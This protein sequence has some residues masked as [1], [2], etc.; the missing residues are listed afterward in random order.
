MVKTLSAEKLANMFLAGAKRLQEKKEWINELNVFPVPDGDTGTNMTMTIMSAVSDVKNIS[1]MNM[2]LLSKALSSG[3]LKGARGNS[4]V[5]LSQLFRGFSKIIQEHNELDVK[6]LAEA[7]VRATETAYKAVMKPK[8]GTILTVAKAMA[9]K[10][11]E[12]SDGEEDIVT[13][14][15]EVLK[16]GQKTLDYT[17]ELLP[18]L[19]EAGVV[20]SG[21]Q[22]LMQV[23]YGA[24]DYL[25]GKEVDIS[26]F[27]DNVKTV[28]TKTNKAEISTAD[29]KY[30]YCTEFIIMLKKQISDTDKEK[31]R[32]YLL[33][34]G[35][36]LVFVTDEDII[37]I[38]VHTNNPGKAIE[39]ALKYGELTRMK[40]DNMKEEHNELIKEDGYSYEDDDMPFKE[41]AFIAVATGEGIIDILKSIGV[42][43]VIEGGQTM[44]PST[45]DICNAI[46]KVNAKNV[47]VLPNNKNII[48]A[49]DQSAKIIKDKNVI[50]IPT[51]N[52]P[53]CVSAII[54]FEHNDDPSYNKDTMVKAMQEVKSGEV[55]YSVRDT[56]ID[57]FS[58]KK[59]DF[60]GIYNGS[61]KSVGQ[62]LNDTTIEMV[63]KMI[64][65]DSGIIS[66]YYGID[67]DENIANELKE[68]LE[69]K[70]DDCDVE[71]IYGG[72]PVYY[73]MVSVE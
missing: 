21:G 9:D 20:D 52:I 68:R 63:E 56:N 34:L 8:E 67:A 35:D 25:I 60:M 32:E 1:D 30:Q 62:N 43:Y 27:E 26:N 24:Y 7:F 36:S 3:S 39:E 29:I 28:T 13:F 5:I 18:V 54:N 11:I 33:S 70:F 59:D 45:E 2:L 4:G 73:Y 37:K 44:N 23:L 65:E 19:K 42:D 46:N 61:I 50:I 55:T 12:V 15:N 51:T 31:Y 69:K 17:P 10:A 16:E 57:G 38:H 71:V 6:I 58:I 48:L 49:A 14:F 47:Y 22:G 53:E 66:V 40:I 41:H 72:Q 64:D